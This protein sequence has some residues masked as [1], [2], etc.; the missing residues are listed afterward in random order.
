[1]FIIYYFIS[2]Y[3]FIYCCLL[4]KFITLNQNMDIYGEGSLCGVVH[5]DKIRPSDAL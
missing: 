3:H 1:M 2:L 5:C 4:F